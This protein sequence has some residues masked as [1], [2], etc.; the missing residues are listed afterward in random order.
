MDCLP[1]VAASYVISVRQTRALLSAFFRF[2]LTMDTLAV[3]L[4]IPLTGLIQDF[5]LP[6]SAPYRAHQK[7]AVFGMN[8]KTAE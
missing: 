2:H 6:V 3:Q 4:M 7:K 5:H 8:P 1:N